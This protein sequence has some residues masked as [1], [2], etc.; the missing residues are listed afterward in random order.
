M[1]ALLD[2]TRTAFGPLPNVAPT[3]QLPT[4]PRRGAPRSRWP[5]VVGA[6][7]VAVAVVATASVM[8]LRRS[9][10][11]GAAA[12]APSGSPD[13]PS[14]TPAR[15]VRVPDE[16]LAAVMGASTLHNVGPATSLTDI[17]IDRPECNRAF[18]IL[19]GSAYRDSDVSRIR[20]R[21]LTMPSTK[22]D[23]RSMIDWAVVEVLD[24][25]QA[26]KLIDDSVRP[27]EE[28]AGTT[29]IDHFDG[30][31]NTWTFG[32][33]LVTPEQ[34]QQRFFRSD[35]NGYQC[36]HVLRE[37]GAGVIEVIACGYDIVDEG[38]RIAALIDAAVA[39]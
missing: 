33:P 29:V 31:S 18:F 38:D 10:P 4:G 26:Q 24:N 15:E 37:D 1:D 9:E 34:I 11:G 32:D 23:I 6:A 19:H 12:V 21:Y 2:Y 35:S 5:L 16:T 14:E 36:Q 8:F 22:G 20:G 13:R 27:W 28:C 25:G 30:Q 7:V 3:G 39:E 17:S